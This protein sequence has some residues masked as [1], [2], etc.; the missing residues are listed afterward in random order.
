MGGLK[1]DNE[2]MQRFSLIYFHDHLGCKRA[3]RNPIALS[4]LQYEDIAVRE[5]QDASIKCAQYPKGELTLSL[6]PSLCVCLA[7]LT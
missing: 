5:S 6:S 3:E 1:G 7:V 2:V 4:R